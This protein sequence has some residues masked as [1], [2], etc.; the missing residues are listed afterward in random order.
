MRVVQTDAFPGVFL[1]RP[2]FLS[3][4]E[5]RAAEESIDVFMTEVLIPLAVRTNALVI[6]DAVKQFELSSSF[7]RMVAVQRAKFGDPAFLKWVEKRGLQ[8]MY[9]SAQLCC[10]CCQFFQDGWKD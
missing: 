9:E 7:L 10:F 6:C 8:T 2:P 4:A 5:E 3:T 1:S